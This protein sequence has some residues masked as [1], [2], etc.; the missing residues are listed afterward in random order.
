LG[1][2]VRPHQQCGPTPTGPVQ[3]HFWQVASYCLPM[4]GFGGKAVK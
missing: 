3:L 1:S 4:V 2:V